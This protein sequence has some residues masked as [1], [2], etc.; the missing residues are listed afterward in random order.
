MADSPENSDQASPR[1]RLFPADNRRYRD[2]VIGI[3]GVTHPK[4]E[5]DAENEK[6][7]GHDL[8]QLRVCKYKP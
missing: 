1:N 8:I 7:A 3:G 2:H 5:S 4:K 6:D